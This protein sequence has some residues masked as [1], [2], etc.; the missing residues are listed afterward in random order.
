M[1]T[2]FDHINAISE[3][4]GYSFDD[5]NTSGYTEHVINTGLSFYPDTIFL[6][7]E[8]NVLGLRG[9][10]HYDFLYYIVDKRKRRSK[11][12][13]KLKQEDNL[14]MVMDFYDVGSEKAKEMMKAM[15]EDDLK[16]LS[17]KTN[18]GGVKK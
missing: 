12:F 17:E 2:P 5:E 14:E 7:N 1:T 13:K 11:W 8:A 10:M 16:W 6:V 3:K 9:K 4:T 15:S 18:K